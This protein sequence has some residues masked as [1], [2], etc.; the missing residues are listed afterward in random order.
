MRISESGQQPVYMHPD[1]G[2]TWHCPIKLTPNAVY[3]KTA[4][5]KLK[6][7]SRMSQH[8][9]SKPE[10]F[11]EDIQRRTTRQTP[12]S[13]RNPLHWQKE[14]KHS[15][16]PLN[17]A[18]RLPGICGDNNKHLEATTC[19]LSPQDS[20]TKLLEETS[21]LSAQLIKNSSSNLKNVKEVRRS[22]QKLAGKGRPSDFQLYL[23][24]QRRLTSCDGSESEALSTVESEAPSTMSG[25]IRQYD[26]AK[27]RDCANTQNRPN[28]NLYSRA[29]KNTKERIGMSGSK[30]LS[31]IIETPKHNN[32][33]GAED[34]A[35]MMETD[36][37]G[38]DKNEFKNS[39]KRNDESKTSNRRSLFGSGTPFTNR[40][41]NT[42]AMTQR[43]E[44]KS[45]S[46]DH[47]AKP[48]RSDEKLASNTTETKQLIQG[49]RIEAWFTPKTRVSEVDT[50][51]ND[52][53]Q[54]YEDVAILRFDVKRNKSSRLLL[55]S[56]DK[57]IHKEAKR[58]HDTSGRRFHPNYS[59]CYKNKSVGDCGAAEDMERKSN[60][61]SIST[62]IKGDKGIEL[63]KSVTRSK[64][65]PREIHLKTPSCSSAEKANGSLGINSFERRTVQLSEGIRS[66]GK[67]A[68]PTKL[69]SREPK[70]A[71]QSVEDFR[72][73][74][75]RSEDRNKIQKGIRSHLTSLESPKNT[76][77]PELSR[78]LNRGAPSRVDKNEP[79]S[80]GNANL[81]TWS[82]IDDTV[83]IHS[84]GLKRS[85]RNITILDP[86]IESLDESNRFKKEEMPASSHTVE[87]DAREEENMSCETST[88]DLNIRRVVPTMDGTDS[89]MEF[90]VLDDNAS[91]ASDELFQ[92]SDVRDGK[93]VG[94]VVTVQE[95]Q[96]PLDHSEGD[97]VHK[98]LTS[99]P[100]ETESPIELCTLPDD[101]SEEQI[102]RNYSKDDSVSNGLTSRP[103]ETESPVEFCTL[104]D[105][106]SEEQISRNHS[107]DDSAHNGLSSTSKETESPIEFCSLPDDV[108]VGFQSSSNST[109]KYSADR[110]KNGTPMSIGTE[111]SISIT[112]PAE[113]YSF[114]SKGDSV[115]SGNDGAES[116]SVE[117]DTFDDRAS[118]CSSRIEDNDDATSRLS[119][120]SFGSTSLASQKLNQRRMS[121]RTL[122]PPHP[123][124]SLQQLD[125]LMLDRKRKELKAKRSKAGT[126]TKTRVVS[127]KK[128]AK[129]KSRGRRRLFK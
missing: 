76:F 12:P 96:I 53:L 103:K 78:E 41:L 11:T 57:S 27:G 102:S 3:V 79:P 89:R 100:K 84:H 13:T 109:K 82:K 1:H 19:T 90:D 101:I 64:G 91:E 99:R 20:T 81:T 111:P 88:R 116:P 115:R 44:D 104:T 26:K 16:F 45:P 51:V 118:H 17:S 43:K 95:K 61:F 97:S 52:D 123:I 49:E 54:N 77:S 34:G 124:C 110:Q 129:T 92:S 75:R 22:T 125:E 58:N 8:V 93:I 15:V 56:T 71:Q 7:Q 65:I 25:L 35:T 86:E 73:A 69:A 108:S 48:L 4:H 87:A 21:K 72:S 113:D 18:K 128:K 36:R 6:K 66:S 127:A 29:L 107:E 42:L 106:I 85:D 67:K 40:S 80:E 83:A 62:P 126:Q 33:D 2:S 122:N 39:A 105:D 59:N 5:G 120:R 50:T 14:M 23:N 24:D 112:S 68:V 119:T 10:L 121:W 28:K 32:E 117:S 74:I 63:S 46:F 55:H 94:N 70:D 47:F 114:S 38:D 9:M 30:K 98:E 31:P 60:I 37:V